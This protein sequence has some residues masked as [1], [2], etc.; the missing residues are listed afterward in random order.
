MANVISKEIL[1]DSENGYCD[2]HFPERP[3]VPAAVELMWM[4]DLAQEHGLC[5]ESGYT[6]KN[7]KLIRELVPGTTVTVKLL[8]GKRGWSGTIADSD[9]LFAQ[10]NLIF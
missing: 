4:T 10:C 5:C 6:V 1:V 2:G 7:M 3:I 8:Q 9:G